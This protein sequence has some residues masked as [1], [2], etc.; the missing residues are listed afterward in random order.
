[1]ETKVSLGCKFVKRKVV[2]PCT[3]K[4]S[5]SAFFFLETLMENQSLKSILYHGKSQLKRNQSYIRFD[6]ELKLK[7]ICS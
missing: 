4:L 2:S 6:E 7:G 5:F 3:L 1:M